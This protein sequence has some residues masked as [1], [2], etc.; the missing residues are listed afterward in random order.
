MNKM[1]WKWKRPAAF[2]LAAAMIFTMPGVPASAVE[3]GVSAVHTGLCEHHPEHTED[4]GYTEGTEGAA[5]KHEHTE[6]CY[7]LVKKCIHEHDESCG[8]IPATEGTPC[9]YTCEQCN[10]QDSGLVPGASGN[11][12]AEC[13]C[14]IRC[15]KEAVNP[16]CPV[17]SAED[18]DLSACKGTEET[19][20]ICTDRCSEEMVNPDCPIC[21]AE[22]ADF[23]ACLGKEAA[24]LAVQALIDALPETVTADNATKIEEQLKAID[25]KIED[26]T[27]EQVAKLDMTRYNAVYAALAAFALPQAAHTHCVCGGNG[28]VNG[29]THNN[30]TAWTAADSLPG[31]AGSYYLTQ[32]VSSDWT[33]PTGEVNLCLNGQTINGKITV[34]SGATLTL[35]DCTGTG[36]LQGSRSGS[37]VSINGGTFNLY[38][39]TITGFV[40][41][42]EIGSHNDIK[43]GSSFTMYGGAITG[44]KADSSG[45]GGV[46]LIGTTN[47]VVTAPSFT[48]HGGT[49]SNNTAGASDG[50]GGGVYVGVKCSFTMDGGTITGNTATAGN[51]GGIYIHF[52]AGK[53]S[54]SGGTITGNKATATGNISCGHGGGIYS[55]RGVTVGNV[56][57]TGN[58]STFEGGGIYGKGAITL[59]DATVTDNNQYDVYYDGKESTTPELTVSGSVKAGY[60]ANFDWKLPI[61]VSG[62]LSENSVI[63]VGVREGIEHG[64]IAEPASGVTLRAENFKA[65]AADCVT[66]LGDDGKVYLVP[67]THEMDDTGYTCSKCGTTFDARVGE[68]AYYQTLTKAFDAARGNTVTLLRDVTLT[69]NCSS[70]TYSATLDLNGKTVSSDRYYICVGGGNKPNTLTVKDSGTGGGT[71]ALTVKFLVYSNGTLAVDNSY[72]GKISR[73]E[74]QAG[75]ALERFG[76]EIGELVLSNAAHG[77]TS[78]GYGLKLWKG[79]TNACT[80]GGFTDNTTSKSLTVN[81]LLGTAYAKCELYGEK[82]GTWSIVDKSTKIAELTGYTAYK[83]QFPECVHQCADDSNPVCSVCHKKLYTKITAKA[84]DGTTKTAYFTEDSALENGY[85]EAIQTLNGWSNEGCTEP[86]LTLLRDM[87]AYG[88]SMPLTGTL[89]LKGGTHTAKNVT[90][91]EGADVTFASG[92]YIGA[93]IDGTAT[94]KEGVT[95]TDA[96]V[97]VNG[98]LNAKG[99]TFTGNVKFNGSSIANISGG[100]FNNEKKYGG[101]TFDYNV[102]GTITGGTF[103]FAD[104]YTTKVKLSGG[105]FTIIKSN[106]DRKLADL[107][108]EGAAY[109]GASDNQ[110]VTNDGVNTL[111]N[112]KVVSHTH[113]GGTDGKGICSVCKKQM[114]ASLTVGGK[115]S[116]YAAFATAIEAANAADGEKTITLYQDVNGYADGHSTTYELTHGPVTLAT[117]GKSVT[118]ANLTAKGISLTV[119]GSNGG[120]NV[121]VEGKDAELTVNDKDT[122]LAIVTA[123]NGGKLSLSN[124]TFS[125]VAVKDDGSSASLS[126]GSYGEITSDAGYVKPYA[127]LAKGYAYKKTRDNQWLPNAN[128]IPSEVTVEKAPFAVEKIYPNS[129]TNYTGNSAFATDGNITLTAVIASEPETE[130][131]TYYYWWELFNES[132]ND[133]TTRFKK[134]NTATHTGEKSKTLTISGLPVDKSYQYHIFVQCDNG[135]QCYSEPFT[136]TQHQH[137]WTYSASGATI[138]AKCTA[139]GCYLTD[140]NGGSVTIAAPAE[141]TYS[142]EGK[143]ATVTAS[144]DWQ[145]PAASGIT[146]SYIKTGTYGQQMLENGALPTDA[147]EYTA[148]ITVG[149]GNKAA[150]A[151]VEYT[152]Q[153][154]NPVV[155]EWPTLSASVYV[156][157]EATLTGGSGEGTFAFKA[158]AA[159][160]WDSAGSKT[161]TIVFTPTDTN[162]YKELTQD[163]NVTVVKRTVKSCHTLTGIT[164]KPYGTAL[165]EL[166][167]PETVTITTEDGKTFDK[168]PVTWSGY[169]PNTLE[170]QTLTGTLDLTSIANEVEQPGMPVTAQIKVKL[171]QKNF[172]GISPEAYDGVYDGKAHGITLTGVPSGA[173][174]KYGESADSCTQDSLT[175]TNFTNG[176]KTVFYKVSQFGYADASGS[177]WVN[178]TKRPLTVSSITENK[179]YAYASGSD[180]KAIGVNIAGKLPTDRGT[181]AYA[182]AKTDTEKLLSE[183]TVDT[184]GNLTYK[185]NQVDAS[186]VGKTAI[187]TV[188]ASMEN[189]ANAGYTLTISITDK[190]T[191]EIKSGN[192]VSVDGSNA[193]TY[194]EK[195]SKLTLGNTVFVEAGTD[196]VI[197]GILSWSN[198]DEIPAAGTTQAGWVFKPADSTYYA[199][200]TGTAAITVAKATP[201]V[202][203]VPTVA[204]RGYNPDAALTGSDIT[205]GSVTG[206]DGNS[207]AGTWSFTGTNIIPTVNNKGYQA[208]FT[209]DDTNNYNTVTRTITVTVNKA[210]K[211]PNMPEAAMTPAHSTK[212]VGNITLQEGWSWQEADKD[213]AL[214]DGVAV[215]ATA[216]YTGA[217][218]GNYE[219]ESVSITITRSKCDHTHTEIRNQREATCTQTGYT[220][221]TYCTDCDQ[222]LR[223]GKE[224][225]ALG[226]NYKA[227]VTKQPTTTEEG[228]RTYTCTKC[229]HSYTQSIAKIKSDDSSK[230][231][232]NEN[233]NP[234]SDDSS[235]DNGSQ[236]Q[237][238]QSGTGNGNQNQ[239]PQPDTDK[240]KEKGDSIKPYIKDESDKEGWD[241]IKPQL[242]ETKAGDTV[243][244]AMNGTTVVPKDVIDSIKGKDTTLVLDMGNGLS[245]KI[246]GKDITNAAGDIDFDVTVGADAGKSIPVD[247]I[248]NVTGEHSSL[249]LTLAYDGEFG[250]T[251]TLT[252][253]ME[254]KNAGLYA[255]LFYYNEQTGELEFISAGQIDPDGNV[256]LV[257]THASDYTIVVD[258]KSMSDNGQAD[259]KAD[260]TI[261]A[262][263]TDDSTSK[264]A[265]NNTIIV[266]IG[267]CIILI[268]TGA[269]F[270]VRKKSGLE[271]E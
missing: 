226:H 89:T 85:V 215:T 248:N 207:L 175:Y 182:V 144:S 102:T 266:I 246:Y 198:P 34:G 204:E 29:H 264:Y 38:G 37:G 220:G 24:V 222:L 48:M 159:K 69:G 104:F 202:V 60:Y 8:Y 110:A 260:E 225:A 57:I 151:S 194:G 55:E 234:K 178:I 136:V 257:F 51:G 168:I 165:E 93:T 45:G 157:S 254:S 95:F 190:K 86:T 256:E 1:K 111:E 98:T 47:S 203:T 77:S 120:F 153:K 80:I 52:N 42:V 163:Y 62:E 233:Q 188:T 20:C 79:N 82:D 241:V 58:N 180:G 10:S 224:L 19:V 121:T 84:A 250:F 197:E 137:S 26:L 126:G 36:K 100:S 28:N 244:V 32:S 6:D 183:V 262:P 39:G 114:A 49:I 27:D 155:T 236:N 9:G 162:N 35:T 13:I 167:L 74:L 227:T 174:V 54:I 218:K 186:K 193:L 154:A 138:T 43:T 4:C 68:S 59:T 169:N 96:S 206:A 232:G 88:T 115:T 201:I 127:L 15:E 146:I 145:G 105:T 219:T 11:A 112:V 149:E 267:I 196:D 109:Y 71:Q 63:H 18:A 25:A 33:V 192:T 238:P 94:V 230:N 170:E 75:G 211:A 139:E 249:N 216:V 191:V 50:G 172:S 261:P 130:N 99:G 46:F 245:W 135:Y 160:S 14:E 67:C 108:A 209:P 173:T 166:G 177:A 235:K 140:G 223:T 21:S 184:A 17:C 106:G 214:A 119:T 217:D 240:G 265:W 3:A 148:S 87:Y 81:D 128:S 212:K 171:T 131:V 141:L 22:N 2:L 64:A 41:G 142:G 129:D 123:Q 53:V 258:T 200:L 118:R 161:T 156:N 116:W 253:N 164:D 239:K 83:V 147:G 181:T 152:I 270:Y 70:D 213:T 72:T 103:T 255:N 44:N 210:A 143:P 97:E 23:S 90:V 73:V 91:A 195:V 56:K 263:K 117:G 101:V 228:V 158:G 252:V 229:G 189:Y 133:W 237:K 179:T 16:D 113:N 107:L 31:T 134:V 208:V 271:E 242:E 185:V 259:N 269:I 221:D 124:G 132:E 66:S 176:P 12:P 61:L 125:R 40:N 92:S 187:I 78:T 268:V 65:D 150:T 7:T 205:G 122:K 251:A 231:N 30:S 199:E 5:C 76:G 243:T 247:V